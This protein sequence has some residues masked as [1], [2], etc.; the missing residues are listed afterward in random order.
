MS[1]RWILTLI[2]SLSLLGIG[3]GQVQPVKPRATSQP[4]TVAPQPVKS[5]DVLFSPNGGCEDRIVKE[6]GQ[7][8]KTMLLTTKPDD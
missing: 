6:I 7:A 5:V 1:P 8:K 4:A 2:V 3:Q